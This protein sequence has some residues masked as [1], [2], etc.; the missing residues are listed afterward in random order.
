M[1]VLALSAGATV[2]SATQQGVS[3]AQSE[4]Q[5][6]AGQTF[7]STRRLPAAAVSESQRSVKQ[8]PC[9]GGAAE[10]RS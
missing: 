6:T 8:R 2:Q 10:Q 5:G 4:R 7:G 9:M 1:C 3:V